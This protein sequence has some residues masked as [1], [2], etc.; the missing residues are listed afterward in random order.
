MK[1]HEKEVPNLKEVFFIW[2]N[3][4]EGK[5]AK[6]CFSKEKTNDRDPTQ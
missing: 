3:F 1:S 5:K 2:K 4:K 6:T